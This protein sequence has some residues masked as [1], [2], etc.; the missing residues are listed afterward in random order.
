[1]RHKNTMNLTVKCA[2]VGVA[3]GAAAL[4]SGCHSDTSVYRFMS[5]PTPEL[6]THYQRHI[7]V[8]TAMAHTADANRR[9]LN[10]DLGVFFLSDRPSR[11]SYVPIVP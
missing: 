10:Q 6:Q 9:T 11:L 7:D 5:D 4:L 1:M 3:C 2:L 8:K